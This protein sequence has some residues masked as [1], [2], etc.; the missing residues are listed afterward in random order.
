MTTLVLLPIGTRS[1]RGPSGAGRRQLFQGGPGGQREHVA[2]GRRPFRRSRCVRHRAERSGRHRSRLARP[3]S[4]RQPRRAPGDGRPVRSEEP[5]PAA[6][7]RRRRP[8]RSRGLLRRPLRRLG[9]YYDDDNEELVAGLVVGAVSVPLP[10]PPAT[11]TRPRPR[12]RP[13]RSRRHRQ[14]CPA[15]RPSRPCRASPTTSAASSTTC[16]PTAA[17][18]RSGRRRGDGEQS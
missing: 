17:P 1:L 15:I 4:A 13:R 8:G 10:H 12:R 3:P 9:R 11:T 18:G 2:A 16:R 7:Q 14:R 5:G 6:G